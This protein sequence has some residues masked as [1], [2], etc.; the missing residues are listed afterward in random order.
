[1]AL[2][3]GPRARVKPLLRR[4]VNANGETPGTGAQ[5]EQASAEQR[6][7]Q[8]VERLVSG[9]SRVLTRV[10]GRVREEVEDIVAE[11]RAL[12]DR[13]REQDPGD[14]EQHPGV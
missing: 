3:R 13:R 11:G 1:M 9:G 12:H 5:D 8:V 7:E 6:A 4:V 14:D 2:A 10:F